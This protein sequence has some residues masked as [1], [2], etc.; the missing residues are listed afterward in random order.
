MRHDPEESG[1]ARSST[2]A[3]ERLASNP[4]ASQSAA[5]EL[6]MA[7]TSL[8]RADQ[9]WKAKESTDSVIHLAYLAER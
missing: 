3:V 7:R 5:R 6:Q 1:G 4:I 8:E 2:P 9:A